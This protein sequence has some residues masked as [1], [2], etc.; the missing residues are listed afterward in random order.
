[1]ISNTRRI[2][3]NTI[4][5]TSF[6]LF[7]DVPLELI[8]KILPE[9]AIHT[10]P[11]GQHLLKKDL[12][13]TA[14]YLLLEGEVEIYLDEENKPLK[15]IFAGDIIGEISLIDQQSATASAISLCSCEVIVISEEL[16]WKLV[17][18]SHLFSINLL[19]LIANRFRGVNSQV[20]S[21]MKQQRLSEHK[22]TVDDLTQLYNRGWLNENFEPL[23][24]CCKKDLQAFSYLMIDI[25]HFKKIN[26]TYGHQVGDFVLQSTGETL[27]SLSRTM[28][29]VV[30]YGGE[31]MA[32][33]LLNTGRADALRIAERVRQ[34]IEKKVIEYEKG[35]N[36]NITVSIGVA[37]LTKS[38][39]SADLIR[40]ADEALY[41]AK[42]H[43][44]NQV[45]FNDGSPIR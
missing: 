36:F 29:Y 19:H 39:T 41:F 34:T 26:D 11:A 1:M 5:L 37:S 17:E 16:V 2:I 38:E 23:L 27:N 30:R 24:E 15:K 21:S 31:E 42:S 40:C 25:D 9:Y 4:D 18:Q 13:N 44:R 32:M 45:K 33:L 6:D 43:G 3:M 28:D 12:N 10:I 14:L 22:A 7:K 20:V 8:N 35:K